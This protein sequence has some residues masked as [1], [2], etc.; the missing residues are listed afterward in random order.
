L[1]SNR[2]VT[3]SQSLFIWRR[4]RRLKSTISTWGSFCNKSVVATAPCSV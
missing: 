1:L 2:W 3:C 4:N